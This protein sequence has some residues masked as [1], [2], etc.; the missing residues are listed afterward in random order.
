VPRLGVNSTKAQP[1][2][3]TDRQTGM[4]EGSGRAE[5]GGVA[6][7]PMRPT[8]GVVPFPP[9]PGFKAGGLHAACSELPALPGLA[10]PP[11]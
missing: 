3:L 6:P 9:R 5:Q 8:L 11:F 4:T 7:A 1:H 2:R 10:F